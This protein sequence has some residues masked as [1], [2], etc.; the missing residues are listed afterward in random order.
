MVGRLPDGGG[1]QPA[2]PI[3]RDERPKY[4]TLRTYLRDCF[5]MQWAAFNGQRYFVSDQPLSEI[6]DF[7]K[8]SLRQIAERGLN[9]NRRGWFIQTHFTLPRRCRACGAIL[10]FEPAGHK[11]PMQH[12]EPQPG[13]FV[14]YVFCPTCDQIAEVCAADLAVDRIGEVVNVFPW[15]GTQADLTAAHWRDFIHRL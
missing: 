13:C 5:L 2:I 14:I 15:A 7:S 6:T 10:D 9:Q 3:F 1:L 4:E 11:E 8:T 12:G